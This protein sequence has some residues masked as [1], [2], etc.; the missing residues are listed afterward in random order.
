MLKRGILRQPIRC[1]IISTIN[2]KPFLSIK[3]IMSKQN[4]VQLNKNLIKRYHTTQFRALK[5]NQ[6][7]FDEINKIAEEDDLK[8]VKKAKKKIKEVSLDDLNFDDE[9]TTKPSS[10]SSTTSTES[11]GLSTKELNRLSTEA[12][13]NLERNKSVMEELTTLFKRVSSRLSRT[14]LVIFICGL[15]LAYTFRAWTTSNEI[16]D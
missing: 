11:E 3:T 12:L 1:K 14:A 9:S 16:K 13:Q 8:K 15:V 4:D 2:N 5:V 7:L 10:S 6:D